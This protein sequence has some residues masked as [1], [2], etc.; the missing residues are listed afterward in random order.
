MNPVWSYDWNTVETSS[1]NVEY[2]PMRHNR[3]W[4]AYA[5]INNKQDS[6]HVLG[7]NE[8]NSSSQANMTVAQA[9][10]EWPNLMASGLRLGS[11]A[12]TDGGLSWLYDFID[13]ADALN[14]RVDFVAV[15]FYKAAGLPLNC[16]TGCL[17]STSGPGAP[18]GSLNST[19]A[20]TGP[21]A[22]LRLSRTLRES[23]SLW[24]R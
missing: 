8:P 6:T 21:A 19:M 14:Y 20:R 4:N 10:A 13:Q 23:D 9:I 15:H 1:P 17:A 11:P 24:T 5:N 3:Y 2:V 7:F 18:S 16:V 12:P 22:R